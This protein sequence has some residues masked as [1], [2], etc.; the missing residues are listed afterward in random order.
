MDAYTNAAP[1]NG[2]VPVE[3][4]EHLDIRQARFGED[5]VIE[6]VGRKT[7]SP[8]SHGMLRSVREI[9]PTLVACQTGTEAA[10]AA[11]ETWS[12]LGFDYRRLGLRAAE[13]GGDGSALH[14]DR[15]PLRED[16]YSLEFEPTIFEVGAVIQGPDDH[17]SSDRSL[18]APQFDNR[19]Q[20]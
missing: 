20:H 6:R 12:I 3:G 5:V 4:L 14:V 10:T 8:R 9:G 2:G 16:K 1:A 18:G 7:G 19:A 17:S 13:S 11:H 15:R